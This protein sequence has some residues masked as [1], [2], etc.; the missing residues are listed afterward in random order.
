MT[1]S[2]VYFCS[3]VTGATE[4]VDIMVRQLM[5]WSVNFKDEACWCCACADHNGVNNCWLSGGTLF[6][7]TPRNIRNQ[8]GALLDGWFAQTK[9]TELAWQIK[10][11][12]GS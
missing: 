7:L 1:P 12:V 5:S 4:L 8:G 10:G 11:S 3:V 6:S 2:H 9:A